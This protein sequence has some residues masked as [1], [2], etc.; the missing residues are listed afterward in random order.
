MWVFALC[1]LAYVGAVSVEQIGC[2]SFFYVQ[3]HAEEFAAGAA[4]GIFH[5]YLAV[6]MMIVHNNNKLK[7]RRQKYTK[8]ETKIRMSY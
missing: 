8:K 4:A 6:F 7:I 1:P 3:A 2:G 5:S